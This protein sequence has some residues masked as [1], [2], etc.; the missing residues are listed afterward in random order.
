MELLAL[1]LWLWVTAHMLP[2]AFPDKRAQFVAKL[3]EAPYK[4]V[5]ALTVLLSVALMVIG[6][7]SIDSVTPLYDVYD[8]GIVPAL[9]M[10]LVGFILTVAARVP[11]NF[12]RIIRHP[13]LTGFALWAVAHLL[14]NGDLR[15]TVLFGGMAIWSVVTIFLLNK[16]DG[17]FVVPPKQL[18]HKGVMTVAIGFVIF[19]ALVLGHEYFTGVDLTGRAQ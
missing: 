13:E 17:K 16:R 11:N 7:Q 8:I 18:P 15:T 5:F 19:I 9:F 4:G 14:I 2:V 6:W 1:G 12:K 3:G 10:L